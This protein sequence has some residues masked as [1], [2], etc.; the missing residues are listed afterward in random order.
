[1]CP[2]CGRQQSQLAAEMEGVLDQQGLEQALQELDLGP[3]LSFDML[4]V[5]ES[6][7]YVLE[8]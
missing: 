3:S 4:F 6:E 2:I 8:R 1:M 5:D 7:T